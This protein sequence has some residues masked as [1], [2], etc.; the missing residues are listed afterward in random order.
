MLSL[1]NSDCCHLKIKPI[2]ISDIYVSIYV[3]I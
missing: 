1:K 2:I 3:S